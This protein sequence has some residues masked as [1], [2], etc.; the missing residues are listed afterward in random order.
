MGKAL[1][2]LLLLVSAPPVQAQ[3]LS[4]EQQ[5][6][7][8]HLVVQD[9]GSCH[10]LKLTGGLGSPIT[11]QALEGHTV[12]GLQGIILDGIPGTA[13][14]PWRPLLSETEAAWIAAY[15]LEA[16]E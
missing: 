9:C 3:A 5:D 2:V 11:A 4:A 1:P 15:L 12:E 13:M 14:P 7:L 6:R 10:G 16:G 8:A